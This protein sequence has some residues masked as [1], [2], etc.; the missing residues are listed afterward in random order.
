[1]KNQEIFKRAEQYL[2]AYRRK[3]KQELQLKRQAK[4]AGNFYVSDEPKLAFVVRIKGINK[5]N[6]NCF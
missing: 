1:V 2:I 3:Q 5:V 6:L 4:K